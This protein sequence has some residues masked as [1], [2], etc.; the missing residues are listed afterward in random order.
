[1]RGIP[2]SMSAAGMGGML[3]SN[4]HT[5]HTPNRPRPPITSRRKD[6][7][8]KLLDITE[9]PITQQVHFR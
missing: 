7:G 2:R 4:S 6:G 3:R 9:S 5:T 1:M 8:I